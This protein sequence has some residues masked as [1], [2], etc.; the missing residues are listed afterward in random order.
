MKLEEIALAYRGASLGDVRRGQR[1][2]RIAVELAR[3]PGLSFPKQWGTRGQ[4]EG[5]YRFLNNDEVTFERCARRTPSRR[6]A[7][8][9][10][11]AGAGAARHHGAEIQ[12]RTRGAGGEFTMMAAPVDSG[13]TPVWR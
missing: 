6:D 13:F 11:G 12:R 7:V 2:E 10:T 3:N 5:V 9:G 1:L 4:L 8:S